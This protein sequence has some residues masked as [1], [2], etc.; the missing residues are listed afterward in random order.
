MKTDSTRASYALLTPSQLDSI[1]QQA[2][3]I[4]REMG[5][6]LQDDPISLEV[7][8]ATGAD[9][10]GTRVRADG[11]HLRHLIRA[12]A[13]AHFIWHGQ[14]PARS[15][16]V[17]Q[18]EPVFIPVYGAPNVKDEQGNIHYG[19]LDD[20]ARLVKRCHAAAALKSTGYLLCYLHD[21]PLE[22]RHLAMAQAHLTH[23]DK[24]ML[25]CVI[26]E[27]A[28]LDVIDLLAIGEPVA[29]ECHLLHV[30]NSTPP[31]V[32]QPNPLR[33]LRAAARRGQACIVT[34]YMMMGATSPVTVAATLAQGYAE[35]LLGLALTQLYRPG[36]PVVLGLYACPFSMQKMVPVF[37]DP[38]S[39]LVQ[40][41]GA[42]LAR[43]L[44]VPFRADGGVTTS[45]TDDAQA[46]YEGGV[47]THTAISSGAD[48]VLH[49]AG[50]LESGR[51]IDFSKLDR[52]LLA[53]EG[54]YSQN[55]LN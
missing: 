50:W 15:V 39:R 43:R 20:Y 11:A 4:L 1:E 55:Q 27:Q 25:G 18:A 7:L 2:D 35:V 12:S 19:T 31:L 34:A 21:V 47:N 41:A 33:C 10:N 53:L 48:I 6:E 46:G 45:K 13:P 44:G 42:Q 3:Q 51:T 54:Y 36:A 29:G 22:T 9:I 30:I 49:S 26:S 16:Q 28:L 40:F 24:P 23:S 32:Y 8:R 52:E 37:G 38:V 5:I 14:N 17:G